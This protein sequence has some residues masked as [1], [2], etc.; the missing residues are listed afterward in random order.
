MIS[1]LWILLRK[2]K[3]ESIDASHNMDE[4]QNHYAEKKKPYSKKHIDLVYSDRISIK[5][6]LG[7]GLRVGKIDYD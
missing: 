2:E 1:K 5:G 7:P 4:Y 6:C 3:E